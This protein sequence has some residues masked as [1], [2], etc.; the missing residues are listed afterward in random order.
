MLR[1]HCSGC[2]RSENVDKDGRSKIIKP[3]EYGTVGF[4]GKKRTAD[5]CTMCHSQIEQRY[6][7]VP[8]ADLDPRLLETDTLLEP[9]TMPTTLEHELA[10]IR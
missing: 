3:R 6:F 7:D 5:L 4:G 2:G 8:P 10:A 9:P 1:I